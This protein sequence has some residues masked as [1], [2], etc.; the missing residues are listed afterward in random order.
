MS[1]KIYYGFIIEN[2]D[3]TSLMSALKKFRSEACALA[4]KEYLTWFANQMAIDCDDALF[5]KTN[6]EAPT[7]MNFGLATHNRMVLIE[8]TSQRD[9]EV[10]WTF[11]IALAPKSN[12]EWLGIYFCEKPSFRELIESQSWFTEYGYW[13]NSDKPDHLSTKEWKRRGR[14]WEE[15][16]PTGFPCKDMLTYK[17]VTISDLDMIPLKKDL[18]AHAP[19]DEFRIARLLAKAC[20]LRLA[21]DDS[22]YEHRRKCARRYE[23]FIFEN[24]T[25]DK[26]LLKIHNELAREVET[27][28]FGNSFEGLFLS[29]N[30]TFG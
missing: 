18:A 14:E 27:H 2:L 7:I 6:Q 30:N 26:E 19:S 24:D 3:A 13:N 5:F 10:D 28:V 1:T 23:K 11:E 17:L 12:N 15:I 8:A 29:I 22:S 20:I 16:F 21:G 25:K 9:P 4:E